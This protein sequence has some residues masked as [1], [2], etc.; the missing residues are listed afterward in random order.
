MGG[1]L[2]AVHQVEVVQGCQAFED[3]G[4]QSCAHG[5]RQRALVSL[6]VGPAQA[7]VREGQFSQRSLIF[8]MV[9]ASC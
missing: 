5:Q 9:K 4:Q 1:A 3:V 2:L 7:Q 6:A 8:T